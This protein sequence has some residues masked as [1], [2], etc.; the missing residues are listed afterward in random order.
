M[1]LRVPRLASVVA[2]VLGLPCSLAGQASSTPAPERWTS[3]TAERRCIEPVA[4]TEKERLKA[5][6][7]LLQPPDS[8]AAVDFALRALGGR[9]AHSRARVTA[10]YRAPNGI[11]IAFDLVGDEA[12][13]ARGEVRDGTITVYLQAARCVTILGW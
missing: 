6:L 11:L 2:M 13:R 9:E 12:G 8:A 3:Q 4:A 5:E 10:Y 1:L 7:A